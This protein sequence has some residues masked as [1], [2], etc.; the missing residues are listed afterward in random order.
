MRRTHEGGGQ[1]SFV[2]MPDRPPS[3]HNALAALAL[4]VA[5]AGC[6]TRAGREVASPGEAPAEL[7]AEPGRA[8]WV[9]HPDLLGRRA[10]ADTW[11]R[12][13]TTLDA[14]AAIPTRVPVTIGA[15]TKYWLYVN[16]DLV[17]REGGLKQGPTPTGV[18]V[19]TL[20][21]AP[22]LEPGA[23]AV[24]VEL[25]HFGKDGFSHRDLGRAALH[26]DAPPTVAVEPWR[27]ADFPAHLR[28]RDT[29]GALPN[30]RLPESNIRFDA[31]LADDAWRAGALPPL[32]AAW[33]LAAPLDTSL[34]PPTI[35]PIPQWRDAGLRRY[36]EGLP[37]DYVSTGDTVVMQLPYNA[38]VTPFFAVVAPEAGL[39]IDVRTDNYRGGGPPNVRTVYYTREGLNA[40]E[41]PGWM[42]G[43]RVRYHFP[44]G[45]TVRGLSF[46]ESGYATERAGGW[47][48]SDPALDTLWE[49]AARTLYIT[50]RDS[51]MDCPDRERA[52]WWGDVVIELGEAFY[53]FDERSTLLA[54]KGLYELM[55]WQRPDST[56]YSP[57]PAGNWEQ[58]LPTQMLASVGEFGLWTY[59]YYSGDTAL[60]EDLY[61][62]V[63][64]YLHV[65]DVDA[66]G[67]VVP[68]EGGWTWGDWGDRKDLYLLYQGWYGLALRGFR[69]MAE[70]TGRP[71]DAVW[72]ERRIE[73]L[74][75]AVRERY[76]RPA[77]GERAGGFATPDFPYDPDDRVQAL[78]VLND[79]ATPEEY[80]TLRATL[81]EVYQAS[82]YMERYVLE[83]L[84]RMGY[85]E[86]AVAR[87]KRRYRA[88]IDSELTTLWEGW[89]LGAEGFG[90]GTY[91]HAWSGG[92][93]TVM[94]QRIAGLEPAAPGWARYRVAPQ[95]SGLDSVEA[96][97]P[98][99]GGELRVRWRRE[100]EAVV[101]EITAPAGAVG[102]L[103]V[104]TGR[105]ATVGGRAA[106]GGVIELSGAYTAVSIR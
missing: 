16:G 4:A 88:M 85:G 35:R 57:V 59:F 42:N 13:R 77:A 62:A 30:Y 28:G 56:I 5:L 104:P 23:N 79:W 83:A 92:P 73:A 34:G 63:R 101:G 106:V 38:Q 12:F 103:V 33:P 31:R 50:M 94:S 52:Q 89:G 98:V 14:G 100:G 45:V 1:D 9:T 102:E 21:L 2:D 105:V 6:A 67:L 55:R 54:R 41:T 60:V 40:F 3:R 47:R 64:R 7:T 97:A 20:D 43:H 75:A 22:Y 80:E 39:R 11:L 68:R 66:D 24:A 72:A 46:R 70:L 93:L 76:W 10:P 18:Y 51:Y 96:W 15:D 58:E 49:K 53:A 81:G 26:F 25:W 90:G 78:A 17:V 48:S 44:A 86:D 37:R 82:P 84:M 36:A 65:W 91:N 99:P 71:D 69:H 29:L 87:L 32:P 19:D 61:P 8:A 74:S 27:V 95:L